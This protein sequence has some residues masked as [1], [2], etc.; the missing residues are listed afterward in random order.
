MPARLLPGRLFAPALA[1]AIAA[2]AAQAQAPSAQ[3]REIL[4]A[5]DAG[6]PRMG[7]VAK[8]I[9]TLAEVGYQET[10][11]SALLQGELA[12]A[13]FKIQ[14]GVA[15][16]PTAFVASF[17]NGDGPV[18]AIL[19]EYDALP[20]LSQKAEP[21]RGAAGQDA[22]HACGH[23]IFGAASVA[24][25]QAVKAWMTAHD[26]KGEVRVYGTPA[27]EGGS[28]KVYLV[29]AGLFEDVSATL[30]WHPSDINSAAQT[31]SLAN[32]SGKFRFSGVAAHASAAP[33]KGR[34]ALDGVE[35]LNVAANY[36]R[37]HV[38]AGTRIHYVTTDGGQAPNV[39]PDSAEVYYYVRHT[40][41]QVVR[42]VIGRIR[43]AAD[44][45]AMAT[46]TKVAFEQTGGVYNMLPNDALGRLMDRNLREV[47]GVKWDAADTAFAEAMAPQLPATK[48][49]F[50]SAA[51]VEAYAVG[52]G[53]AGSTDV[54]DVS[55]VTPTAGITTATWVPGTPA[56]SW[57]AVAAGGT[58]MATKAGAVAAKTLALTAADLM[59]DPK[60]IARARAELDERRG[61]DFKYQA[62]V[63]D[64]PPPLDYRHKRTEAGQ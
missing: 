38:P 4:A 37:E 47:G 64:R 52:G 10:Q 25:A 5:V 30:H 1:L 2:G 12:A 60:R 54:A 18:I 57:Q 35:V 19:A 40:D 22:G 32:V 17:K 63:G 21:Q 59:R 44:G 28:G 43:K 33:E 49:T 46:E 53:G 34:S 56:H 48:L 39:V 36:M 15:G 26:V 23:H 20:G 3:R 27:E 41:P 50:A 45:A 6:T 7:E 11:S 58:P 51:Q 55:W 14:S 9:W 29:R 24:A 31:V 62:M 8:R 61:P 13:G 16:M 42:D